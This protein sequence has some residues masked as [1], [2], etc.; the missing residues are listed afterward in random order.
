MYAFAREATALSGIPWGA[1]GRMVGEE[2]LANR[3]TGQAECLAGEVM[4]MRREEPDRAVNGGADPN[5]PNG[6]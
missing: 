6:G 3:E 2:G 1:R 4:M 5:C